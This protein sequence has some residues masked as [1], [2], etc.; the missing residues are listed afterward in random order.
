M[1]TEIVY[2]LGDVMNIWRTGLGST[3]TKFGKIILCF[4]I[5]GLNIN[6]ELIRG[7]SIF[8]SN[9]NHHFYVGEIKYY[10][11]F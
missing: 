11:S 2:N 6:K 1:K 10:R 5:G 8:F 3:A 7:T 4:E 9:I